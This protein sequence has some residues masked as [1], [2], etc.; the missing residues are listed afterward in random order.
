MLVGKLEADVQTKASGRKG[1][2]DHTWY[3]VVVNGQIVGRTFTSNGSAY[4]VIS[5]DIVS[6]MAK[7]LNVSTK[8]FSGLVNCS[9]SLEEYRAEMM[10]RG[11]A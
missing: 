10:R 7:Q 4:R 8:I 6:K 3:H 9:V 2:K 1:Q 11:L 5:D